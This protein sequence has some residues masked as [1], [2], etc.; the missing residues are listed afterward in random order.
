[1]RDYWIQNYLV[2]LSIC[3]KSVDLNAT[4]ANDI[5]I[6]RSSKNCKVLLRWRLEVVF[7]TRDARMSVTVTV[8][9]PGVTVRT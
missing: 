2:K 7:E 9:R 8:H 1:M 5:R 4:K 3:L 6:A